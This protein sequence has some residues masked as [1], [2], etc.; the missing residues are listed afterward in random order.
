MWSFQK[1]GKSL[2]KIRVA[3]EIG[4]GSDKVLRPETKQ[5]ARPF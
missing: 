1:V 5:K 3:G 4:C 2:N